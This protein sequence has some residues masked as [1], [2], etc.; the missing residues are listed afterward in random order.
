MSD[1]DVQVRF[2]AN[3]AAVEEGGAEVKSTLAGIGEGVKGLVDL[4][5]ELGGAATGSFREIRTGAGEAA[6]GV[7]GATESVV[8]F[9][10]A[11]SGIG[12]ALVAAFAV[13]QIT[14]F[15]NK[16]GEGAEKITHFAEAFGLT[17]NEVQRLQAQAALLGIPFES[18]G[19][20]MTR[21]DAAMTRAREGSRQQADAF[22]ALGVNIKAPVDQAALLQEVLEGL[23]NV[24]DPITRV[25]LATQVFGRNIQ[26]I[27]PLIG[28]TTAQLAEYNAVI[29]QSG[30]VSASAVQHGQELAD[31]N[32]QLAVAWSGLGLAL[33]DALAPAL[34]QL[35]NDLAGVV[36]AMTQSYN[37]GGLMKVSLDALAI[38][39]KVVIGVVES[40]GY[41]IQG[42][43]DL[44]GAFG[45]SIGASFEQIVDEAVG[46]F[47]EMKDVV[48][49][50]FQAIQL[51]ATGDM[52]GAKEVMAAAFRQ[53]QADS[54]ATAAKLSLDAATAANAWVKASLDMANAVHNIG[55]LVGGD[56]ADPGKL[57]GS[58]LQL[59]AQRPPSGLGGGGGRGRGDPDKKQVEE[60]AKQQE[61]ADLKVEADTNNFNQSMLQADL[62]FWQGKLDSATKYS[63]LWY[64]IVAKY[65]PF[66]AKQVDEEVSEIVRG[67][68]EEVKARTQGAARDKDTIDSQVRDIREGVEEEIKIHKAGVEAMAKAQK[69]FGDIVNPMVGSFTHGLLEMAEGAK[70]F[71]Q[72]M[73]QM[74]QQ[75]LND[76]VSKVIDP[77]IEKWLW[78]EARQV[79]ATIAGNQARV[80]ADAAGA[81]ESDSISL[82]SSLRQIIHAAHLAASKAYAAEAG[83]P[84][85]P[86]WGVIAGAAAFAGVMAFGASAAGG[87]D[88]PGGGMPPLA[89][90][91]PQEMVLPARIANPLR[92]S[93]AS[94]ALGGAGR[95]GDTNNITYAPQLLPP[96]KSWKQSLQDHESDVIALI[97][98]SLRNRSLRL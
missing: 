18:L 72:E 58:Q 33:T 54:D 46:L 64:D 13:E 27:A 3:T 80:A 88:I 69:A 35:V 30:A 43:A 40:F 92:D 32:N 23:G 45:A 62:A 76:F 25:G 1:S 7:K 41:A 86:L 84:P 52:Q 56:T 94:G 78:K 20:A 97:Q 10:E 28:I 24:A 91:H 44:V 79:A 89:Q 48:I 68:D 93:L 14:E 75:I 59:P 87:W 9:Q 15:I 53:M 11:I 51:A 36:R 81:T 6:A 96:N 66:R 21:A 5:L 47:T 70:S 16:M 60:W 22:K 8:A 98:T 19:M 71:G 57:A 67:V 29:D 26:N 49:G 63:A 50:A 95:G 65:G 85:A 42:A 55:G 61:Q 39:F 31:A 73:R 90:L 82:L 2:G 12:E 74:G 77:M 17:T 83:V 37:S 34:T 38:A 4:F